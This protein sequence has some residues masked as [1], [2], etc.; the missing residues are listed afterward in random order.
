MTE[1]K[2]KDTYYFSHDYNARSDPKTKR[3]L[4][5][6]GMA[7]Y[8][9]YWSIVEDLYNNANALP[10]DYGTIAYDLRCEES[11]IK[12]IIEDFDLFEIHGEYFGSPS[13]ERRLNKRIEK[14]SKARQSAHIRWN[15]VVNNDADAMRTHTDCNAIKGK[16]RKGKEINKESIE[17][18]T[19]KRFLPPSTDEVKNYIS[20]KGYTVDPE[21]FVAFYTS[22]NWY[23]G[24]NKMK[25]WQSAVLTW[26][27]RNREAAPAG[28]QSTSVNE[29]WKQ[30]K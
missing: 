8:G 23:V 9:V 1:S 13:V 14:S 24:T 19:V 20:E 22:K 12:S 7:G 3:L 11:M 29:I 26:E 5:K 30:H 10:A 25:D 6:F 21:S 28:K 16:E 2:D 18:E 17:K 15:K 4:S 27:K